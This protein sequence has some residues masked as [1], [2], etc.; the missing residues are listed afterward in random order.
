MGSTLYIVNPA[1]HGGSRVG[2]W[3]RFR[4]QW[5]DEIDP[6]DVRRTE[7]PEH[8]TRI[9]A[10]CEGCD[11]IA[12]VG[13]D[14]TVN[15]IVQGIMDRPEPRPRLVVIPA[16]TGND[17]ARNVGL[18]SVEDAV[19]AL[20]GD[21][22]KSHDLIGIDCRA[23]GE[24]AH[25]YGFLYGNVGFSPRPMLR[26]WMKRILGPKVTYY[27]A[28]LL[29]FL[30]FRAPRMTARWQEGEYDDIAWII[31]VCNAERTGGDSMCIAPGAR[32]DD[33][34]L[35]VTIVPARPKPVMIAK[36]LP[37]VP[38][39]AHIHEAGIQYFPT[40]KIEVTTDPPVLLEI[41]GE[42]FGATPA[43]FTVCPGAIQV[44]TPPGGDGEGAG[45]SRPV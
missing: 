2:A 4:S 7:G 40:T 26:P 11:V 39:G 15:E 25:R 12:A 27:L 45:G 8:A 20:K 31:M 14:G 17:I 38:T 18:R 3:D 44:L 23:G 28:T 37:K 9:A 16:G 35:N 13:G 41:D 29:Q 6:A 10:E 36:V 19:A 5:P 42:I 33:G 24:P 43:T 21:C 1:A 22:V 34:E 30:V 32:T